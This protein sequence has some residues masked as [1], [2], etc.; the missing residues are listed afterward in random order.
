MALL[1]A[2]ALTAVAILS[3]VSLAFSWITFRDLRKLLAAFDMTH[4]G[5]GYSDPSAAAVVAAG[6]PAPPSTA[7]RVA[8][9]AVPAAPV[10]RAEPPAVPRRSSPHAPPI[11]VGP[12]ATDTPIPDEP[13]RTVFDE[14]IARRWHALIAE[15]QEAG[16]VAKHCFGIHCLRN[17][18]CL[19][20]CPCGCEG[21]DQVKGFYTQ[22][23][24]EARSVPEP[25]RL[26]P[27]ERVAGVKGRPTMA[28]LGPVDTA[29]GSDERPSLWPGD[30]EADEREK[31]AIRARLEAAADARDAARQEAP[32]DTGDDRP[33]DGET[34]VMQRPTIAAAPV[35]KRGKG[36][37]DMPP[38]FR[39]LADLRADDGAPTLEQRPGT[40]TAQAFHAAVRAADPLAGVTPERPASSPTRTAREFDA[41]SRTATLAS[42]GA[43]R[44]PPSK[45]T[46]AP[47]DSVEARFRALCATARGA[48]LA[49][50]HCHGKGCDI[51]AGDRTPPPGVDAAAWARVGTVGLC[52]CARACDGCTRAAALLAQA[53]QEI[54]GPPSRRRSR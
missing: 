9:P 45:E 40:P 54:H 31:R 42:A 30:T 21:C 51:D 44:P 33:S 49:V 50:D 14:R 38:T 20:A 22:A 26:A 34:R 6:S 41:R 46:P 12:P 8:L 39:G 37:A 23:T 43:V 10:A 3:A 32:A 48:G 24:R 4:K 11:K 16:K 35:P 5:N 27:A 2:L 36:A 19:N 52:M 18:Y 29:P 25:L 53:E 13:Q 7:A 15:A 47:E 17:G 1:V 28:G